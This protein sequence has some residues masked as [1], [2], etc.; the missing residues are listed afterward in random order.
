MTRGRYPKEAIR[1]AKK[2]A[3]ERGEVRYY[4][5]G[6]GLHPHFSIVVPH[7]L[8]EVIMAITNHINAPLAQLEAE[9]AKE[10]GCMKMYPAS[11]QISREVWFSSQNYTRR[12]FRI[13][14]SGL[15]ELGP[16]GNLLPIDVAK[17]GSCGTAA[18]APAPAPAAAAA[19]SPG[20]PGARQFP[21]PEYPA[22]PAPEHSGSEAAGPETPGPASEDPVQ[23]NSSPASPAPV[24]GKD[25]AP[26]PAHQVKGTHSRGSVH[27]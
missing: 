21:A 6:P 12:Y 15:I 8:A 7:I 24:P 2:I 20:S 3:Q 19:G 9:A 14:G 23:K 26:S 27:T 5:R 25:A 11:Q 4:E 13:T 16:D 22:V 1:K 17:I 18:G 10:I